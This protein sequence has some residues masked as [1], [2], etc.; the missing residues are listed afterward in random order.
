[1]KMGVGLIVLLIILCL[2]ISGIAGAF[3]G[4]YTINTWLVHFGKEPAIVW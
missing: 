2:S 4:P 1:M 3:C